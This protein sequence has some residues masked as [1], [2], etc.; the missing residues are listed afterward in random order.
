MP[1]RT[2]VFDSI[3]KYDGSQRRNLRPEEYIQ[4][5]GRAGRRGLDEKGTVIILCKMKFPERSDLE[6]M[7][8]VRIIYTSICD[9]FI[10]WD[11]LNLSKKIYCF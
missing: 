2:V 1:A 6:L 3:T 11:Y 9:A 8:Q 10:V 4:M 5:A 7:I